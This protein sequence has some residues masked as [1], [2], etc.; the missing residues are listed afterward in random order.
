MD[1]SVIIPTHNRV[2]WTLRGAKALTRQ[3][4]P[5]NRYEI[6]YSCDRCTDG[7]AAALQREFGGRVRA[8]SAESPGPSGAI[9][10]A[11]KQARGDVIIVLDDEMEA[12][13]QLVEAHVSAHCSGGGKKIIVTGY[14]RVILNDP[15]DS[16]ARLMAKRYED[17]FAELKQPGRCANPNDMCGSNFSAPLSAFREVGGY[18][19]SY[20][21]QRNDFELAVRFM[22]LGYDIVFCPGAET[23]QQ[24]GIS[25][26][27]IVNRA[28]ER[29]KVDC[30]LARE[31]PWC[32]PHL[33][34][35]RVLNESSVR[36]RWR[37][38]WEIAA[39]AA[40]SFHLARK[41]FPD[42]AKLVDLEY[43]ARYCV[44]LRKETGSWHA[45]RRLAESN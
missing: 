44:G 28:G 38:L 9:N 36:R 13:P 37:A 23:S 32:V 25:A 2:Q 12:E 5:A 31:Y 17:F 7:T 34:F 43:A 16:Y 6:I 10:T 15:T 19:E 39:P 24:L 40:A 29:A 27:T 18:S 22:R 30:R 35:F 41:L 33:P 21:F 8:M 14:S 26:E 20:F 3:T 42:N 11:L 45:F 1:A 4:Y